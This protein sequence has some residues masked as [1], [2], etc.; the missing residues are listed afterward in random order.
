MPSPVQSQGKGFMLRATASEN[1]VAAARSTSP[2]LRNEM[3][4]ATCCVEP[5]IQ[6]NSVC[7][8]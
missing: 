5:E 4:E 7:C 3:P 6:L 2:E 8:R 1:L